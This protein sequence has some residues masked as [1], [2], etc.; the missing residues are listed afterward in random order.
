MTFAT[1]PSVFAEY[2]FAVVR[3]AVPKLPFTVVAEHRI[4]P[5]FAGAVAEY[6]LLPACSKS[7]SAQ[8]RER[9]A[10]V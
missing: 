5:T 2:A 3:D 9:G 1:L 6:C 10:M 7:L 8:L 4:R